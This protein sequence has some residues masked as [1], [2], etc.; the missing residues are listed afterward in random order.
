MME[1]TVVQNKIDEIRGLKVMVDRDLAV[2]YGY[3]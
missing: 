3:I 2:M 1:L